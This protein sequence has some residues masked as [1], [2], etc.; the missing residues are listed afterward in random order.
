MNIKPLPLPYPD[1]DKDGLVIQTWNH[2]VELLN[3]Y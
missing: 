2:P 1:P 3:V